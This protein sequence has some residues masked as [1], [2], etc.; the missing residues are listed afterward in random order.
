MVASKDNRGILFDED[1]RMGPF[2]LHLLKRVDKPT[3]LITDNIQR[4][5]MRETAILKAERGEYGAAAQKAAPMPFRYPLSV[6]QAKFLGSLASF[7]GRETTATR[8]PIN[9][10]PQVLTRHI[11]RLGY[12]LGADIMAVCRF[13]PYA[14][15]SHVPDGPV[16]IKYQNAIVM[17]ASKDIPTIAASKG[18]DWIGDPISFSAYVRLAV[19]SEIIAAY[20]NELGYPALPQHM[21]TMDEEQGGYGGYQIVLAPLLVLSGIGEVSRT[22]LILNPFLGIAFKASAVLTDLPLVPDKPIDFGL[23]DF[24][25][26]CTICAQHCPSQAIPTGDKVMYNGYETWEINYQSCASFSIL[27]KRGTM[28]GMCTKVCPWTRPHTWPHK[29]WRWAN[30]HS[31]LARRLSIKSAGRRAEPQEAGKWWFD[32][33]YKDGKLKIPRQKG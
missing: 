24:C 8:A 6:V 22:G 5:D 16:D 27:N 23:Q 19:M 33:T 2:P 21:S 4:F 32:L 25:Q 28:C 31:G 3:T 26:H 10:D 29:L 11:K 30:W 17:V 7:K 13:P 18:Y 15:Y 9:E 14:A 20:I 12:F 1:A